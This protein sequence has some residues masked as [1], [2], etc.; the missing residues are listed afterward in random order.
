MTGGWTAVTHNG[1][2]VWASNEP[3][4]VWQLFYSS[5]VDEPEDD[6]R[7][8]L[9]PARYP[10]A[11]PWTDAGYDRDGGRWRYES[12]ESS[13]GVMIDTGPEAEVETD[14]EFGSMTVSQGDGG[15]RRRHR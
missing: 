9:P 13:F 15:V 14:D 8:H 4:R 12:T 7:V 3:Q 5:G 10:D 6:S 2:D 1:Q 11:S